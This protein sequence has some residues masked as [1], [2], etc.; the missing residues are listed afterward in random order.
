M[1]VLSAPLVLVLLSLSFMPLIAPR[2]W[3]RNENLVFGIISAASIVTVYSMLPNANEVV[4][5][6][7]I[8]DY[9]PFIIMVFTLFTLS[10]G[11]HID[12]RSP[13]TT[14]ANVIFLGCSSFCSSFIG[15]TGASVLFLYP[16]LKMN[17]GRQNKTHLLVFYIFLVSNIGGL[18]TPLGDSPLLLGYLH[19]IDFSW[20]M[21]NLTLYWAI[22]TA[23]CLAIL[24]VV[25][26]LV[27]RS[28]SFDHHLQKRKFSLRISGWRSITLLALTVAVL[29][30]DFKYEVKI[31]L[32]C[33]GAYMVPHICLK[34]ILFL[35]FCAISM[36]KRG[37]TAE[38]I[39]FAPC[40]EV[41]KTFLV[42]FIV[43]APVLFLISEHS[44]AIHRAMISLGKDNDATVEYFWACAITSA[45]LDNAPSF[46]VFFN[47]AGGNPVDLMGSQSN[48]L[49]A[50]SIS[51]VV[52]GAITYVGNAPNL[53][54][55]S[56]ADRKGV[57]MPSFITYMAW[58]C[59]AIVPIS[60]LLVPM[61]MK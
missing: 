54:V 51:G 29:F 32:P 35:V 56:I 31:T 8:D 4:T 25:D 21:K 39:D 28:E 9:V 13:S 42:I 41:A 47:I 60:L 24:V 23:F 2:F 50:I 17:S 53:I 12:L 55:R 16:F 38:K 59:L 14:W 33:V 7:L 27:L 44:E 36:I 11:I 1:I 30:I 37:S 52:M 46:L 40:K 58:A 22:Y 18:L 49:T 34:N 5:H 26:K 43:I 15:T 61:M 57:K 20:A 3:S 19:G 6:A 45:F 10:H 48:I